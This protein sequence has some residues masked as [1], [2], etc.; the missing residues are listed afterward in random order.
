MRI[1]E[2]EH[3]ERLRKVYLQARTNQYYQP[4]ISLAP[5]KAEVSLTVR[6]DFHHGFD[7]VHGSVYFKLLDDAA[8]FAAQTKA[9]HVYLVT[10]SFHI[11]FLRPISQGQM[12]AEGELVYWT[13]RHF[14]ADA[15]VFDGK[16]R[17]IARGSGNFVKSMV[18]IP[19]P[20]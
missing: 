13:R 6:D 4:D 1:S 2:E 19:E 3:L 9:R 15:K 14:V 10:S 18:D 12:R 5:G 11:Q 17:E 8:Y 20:E 7:A 16:G